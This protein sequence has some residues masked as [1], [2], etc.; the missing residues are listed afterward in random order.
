MKTKFDEHVEQ[1]VQQVGRVLAGRWIAQ[2]EAQV[3]NTVTLAK[4]HSACDHDPPVA[5]NPAKRGSIH[6]ALRPTPP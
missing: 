5:V 3:K 4:P 2:Q 6:N 1:L